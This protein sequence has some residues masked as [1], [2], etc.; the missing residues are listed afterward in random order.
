MNLFLFL[1]LYLNPTYNQTTMKRRLQSAYA[2]LLSCVLAVSTSSCFDGDDYDFDRLS[3]KVDWTPNMIVPVGYGTYSLWY[4]LNQHEANPD[5]QTI[6]LDADG[7]LHIKHIEKDLFSY[8]VSEVINFPSQTTENFGLILPG[9]GIPGPIIIPQVTDEFQVQTSET[10]IILSEVDLNAIIAFQFS[11][12]L[13][14]NIR[15]TVSLPTGTQGGSIVSQTY[16]IASGATNQAETLDLTNLNLKFKTPYSTNNALDIA[17]EG[18]ILD[19]GGIISGA[20]NLAIQYEVQNIDFVLAQGDFGKQSIDIGSGNLDMGVDFWD[21]V[22]G[23]YKFADPKVTLHTTNSVGVPFEINAD[24]TGYSTDGNSQALNP[25]PLQ[26]AYPSNLS[27]VQNGITTDITYDKSNSNIVEVMALPPSDRIEYSGSVDLNPNPVDIATSPNIISNNSRIDVDLEID[28]PLDFSATNLMLRDTVNDI[29]IDDA[30]KIMNAAIVITAENG[31]PLNAQIDKIYLTDELY[32]RIDSVM[33]SKVIDAADVYP[34]THA[35]AGEVNKES[36]KEVSHEI[37]LTQSQIKHL[38]ETENLI[39]NASVK[40]SGTGTEPV[41]LKGDY[42][43]K[44]KI[45]VQAQIDLNN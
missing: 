37:E 19:N 18:S 32:N 11:N 22:E 33:D 43:L 24:M 42:E 38:N 20:G 3:D 12:P 29:S 28:I 30:E 40:T 15:L 16:T 9:V 21:D 17:F 26:P 27:E 4:L 13:N 36:I 44:F 8:G 25:D 6:I 34:A 23:D 7:L 41:K 10:D 14:A 45:S 31:Y 2:L 35:Q 39:I 1:R 5:D